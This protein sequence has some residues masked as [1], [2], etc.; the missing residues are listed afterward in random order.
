[1]V[2]DLHP[3]LLVV[4]DHRRF[5]IQPLDCG[6]SPDANQN[7]IGGNLAASAVALGRDY[8]LLVARIP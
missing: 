6:H 1:M 3:V 8:F 2:V 4:F 7:L 5:K